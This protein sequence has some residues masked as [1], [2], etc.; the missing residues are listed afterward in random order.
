MIPD[1]CHAYNKKNTSA[2]HCC[3][4]LVKYKLNLNDF[5]PNQ[6]LGGKPPSSHQTCC[7]ARAPLPHSPSDSAHSLT[8][9]PPNNYYLFQWGKYICKKQEKKQI[10][11]KADTKITHYSKKH[12]PGAPGVGCCV[13]AVA[14]AVAVAFAGKQ[15]SGAAAGMAV[16]AVAFAAAAAAEECTEAFSTIKF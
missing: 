5:T 10:N 11:S 15:V 7:A 9:P 3:S 2:I 14:L 4:K 1:Q 13:P 12:T 8:E 16:V 6:N